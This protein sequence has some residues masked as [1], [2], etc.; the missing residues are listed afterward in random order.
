MRRTTSSSS[1]TRIRA[2][3][4]LL[5]VPLQAGI[6]Q[7]ALR[8]RPSSTSRT[9]RVKASRMNGF[10]RK[11]ARR[12]SRALRD[13]G[14]RGRRQE[15]VQLRRQAVEFVF[16]GRENTARPVQAVVGAQSLEP[17]GRLGGRF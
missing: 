1:I 10:C 5:P 6:I 12:A 2:M 17:G 7:A 8:T 14:I 4:V 11:A 13:L 16:E 3:V 15:R 9:D